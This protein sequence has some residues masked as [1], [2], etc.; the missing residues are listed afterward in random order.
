M[1]KLPDVPTDAIPKYSTAD[2]SDYS[3]EYLEGKLGEVVDQ[4]A[5]RWG[6]IVAARL[7]SGQLSERLY[8]AVVVRVASREFRNTDGYQRENEGQYGY[9]VSALVASGY[10]WF[11]DIDEKDLTGAVAPKKGG[12]VGTITMSR[13]PGWP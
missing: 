8:Q 7:A 10:L 13:Q 1:A 3:D 12:R 2:T 6:S 9:E 5:S 4:I 11:T